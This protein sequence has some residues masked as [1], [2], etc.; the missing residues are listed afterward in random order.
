MKNWSVTDIEGCGGHQDSRTLC[1]DLAVGRLELLPGRRAE[2]LPAGPRGE[3][4]LLTDTAGS[5][6]E[7]GCLLVT[8]PRGS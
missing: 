5:S 2:V 8:T 1:S 7:Q 4:R 3:P 6:R